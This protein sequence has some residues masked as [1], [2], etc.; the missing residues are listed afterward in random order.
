MI[1]TTIL[2]IISA[3]CMMF[4]AKSQGGDVLYG[5]APMR[6]EIGAYPDGGFGGSPVNYLI[7]PNACMA[8]PK[9][10]SMNFPSERKGILRIFSKKTCTGKYI[11]FPLSQG[12]YYDIYSY[13]GFVPKTWVLLSDLY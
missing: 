9:F 4:T 10:N 13:T 3:T 1:R 11:D 6:V 8:C 7:V 2:T 5:G 12:Y